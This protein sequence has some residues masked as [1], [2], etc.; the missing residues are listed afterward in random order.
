MVA[1]L[2]GPSDVLRDAWLP[3]APVQCAVP[4]PRAGFVAAVDGRALGLTVVALGG[5]RSRPGAVIDPRVGLAALLA[6]GAVVQTGDALAVVHAASAADAEAAVRA[7]T[8][9]MPVADERPPD[10][11]LRLDTLRG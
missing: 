7:V 10:A 2:G 9:A 1:R 11:P 8:A 6:P 4:A 5:G 3:V